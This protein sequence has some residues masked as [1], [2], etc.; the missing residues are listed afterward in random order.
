VS[1]KDQGTGLGLSIAHTIIETYGG[2]IW[3]ENAPE[4]GA[5]FRFTLSLADGKEPSLRQRL[6]PGKLATSTYPDL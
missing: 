5:I 3:A 6:I 4:G 2:K 1:T